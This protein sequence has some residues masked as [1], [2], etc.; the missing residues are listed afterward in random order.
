MDNIILQITSGRGP[1]ECC[2]VVAQILRVMMDEAKK[3]GLTHSLLQVENGP[4]KDTLYSATIQ[5]KGK[6]VDTF[7]KEWMGSILWVGRSPYRP[8]HKRK[9]WFVAVNK[10]NLIQEEVSIPDQDIAYQAIR[11]GGPG[12]QHVNKVSTAIRATHIPSKRSILASDSRSQ[13]QNRK[14]AKERLIQLLQ[15]DRLQEKDQ[16]EK[17]DW[18]N[19]NALQRGNPV[20]VFK[21]GGFSLRKQN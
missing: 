17:E 18:Q 9:N 10:L 4:E 19:H 8:Y 21:G 2:W 20:K 13:L 1:A 11:S 16:K 3:R 15:L 5:L 12:G 6:E 14:L 7:M